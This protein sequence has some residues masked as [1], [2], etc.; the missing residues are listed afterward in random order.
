ATAGKPS[1]SG[2]QSVTVTLTIEKGWHIYANPVGNAD[3]EGADTTV[4]V[5][6]KGV[7]KVVKI[8]YPP[9]KEENSI[10]GKYKAYTTK[11]VITAVVQRAP[12]NLEPLDVSVQYQA[13][14][15]KQCLLPK[16]IKLKVP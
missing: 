7:A 15:D 10:L 8:T 2:E 1:D 4:K 14:D 12:G 3:F 13:C 9:G 11:A 6:G 5:T 16:T